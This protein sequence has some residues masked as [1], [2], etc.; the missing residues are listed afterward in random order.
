MSKRGIMKILVT[1][2]S[3]T[4]GKRLIEIIQERHHDGVA[5]LRSDVDISDEKSMHAY[6]DRINPDSIMHL[7]KSDEVMTTHLLTWSKKHQKKF[8]FTSSY[9]V[10][11]GKTVEAP[12]Q[13][14]DRPDGTDEF[15]V[16][17]IK[18][19]DLCFEMYPDS[20]VVRL[21]WQIGKAPGGYN[22][23][24]F[25]SEQ[26][27]QRGVMSASKGLYLSLMFLDDTCHALIDL[28]ESY[29]PGMYHLNQNDGYSFYDVI[30]YLKHEYQQDWIVL[31]DAKKFSKND[32][33][34]NN[35]VKVRMFSEMGMIHF[36]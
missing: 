35:K 8:V 26:M 36:E 33:M 3:G 5:F 16:G 29:L 32:N 34:E 19:E 25:V 4:I 13:V 21:A 17:K 20:Y 1:G 12:Y 14:Y 11:S 6:L 31:D 15:A 27:K 10:F 24:S 9:K 28:V 7:A 18:Q 2:A 30:H 22:M 23:L